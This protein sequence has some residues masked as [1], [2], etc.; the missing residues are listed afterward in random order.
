MS[1]GAASAEG[2][3]PEGAALAGEPRSAD[4]G[5]AGAELTGGA[6]GDEVAEGPD[7]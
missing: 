4:A 3:K 6:W 1:A 2:A 5:R 7:G